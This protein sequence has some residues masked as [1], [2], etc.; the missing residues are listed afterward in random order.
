MPTIDD[1]GFTVEQKEFIKTI[2]EQ[3]RQKT[4]KAF[5]DRYGVKDIT[6]LDFLFDKAKLYDELKEREKE[7]KFVPSQKTLENFIG[8]EKAKE[9]ICKIVYLLEKQRRDEL[10]C[11]NA[12]CFAGEHGIGKVAIAQIFTKILF[13]KGLVTS[14]TPEVICADNL[15]GDDIKK[16][17]GSNT[18]KVVVIKD[19]CSMYGSFFGHERIGFLHNLYTAMDKS[20]K[21]ITI[22]CDTQTKLQSLL[23]EEKHLAGRVSA[24]IEFDH[25]SVDELYDILAVSLKKKEYAIDDGAVSELKRIIKHQTRLPEYSNARSLKM[26]MEKL[27]IIQATRTKEIFEDRVITLDD[28]YQYESQEKITRT[29]IDENNKE[30]E[31]KLNELIGLE[32]VKKQIKRLKAYALKNNSSSDNLN[33]HMCFTGNPGTGKTVVAKLVAGILYENGILPENKLIERDRSTLIGKYVGQTAPL[34]REAVNASLG[35]VLF[36][37]EAYALNSNGVEEDYGQEAIAEL[38]KC[39]EEQR[40]QFAVIFAGYKNETLAMIESNPGLKSRINRYVDFPNY[41]RDELIQITRYMVKQDGYYCS[42]SVVNKVCDI[43]E[44]NKEENNYGNARDVRNIL[45]S[46]YEI[47]AERTISNTRNRRII[48][49]DVES[50]IVDNRVKITNNKLTDI[51]ETKASLT[52]L[53]AKT[54]KPTQVDCE[55]IEERTVLIKN[56]KN[57]KENGE[58]TGFFISNSGIILTNDHVVRGSDEIRVRLSLYLKNGSKTYKECFAKIYKTNKE[59]DVAILKI[60]EKGEYPFIPMSSSI[61]NALTPV[62][63]GGYPYGASRLND[64]SFSEGVVQSINKD[65]AL[66]EGQETVD[67]IYVDIVGVPGN[68][69]SALINK[70][71]GEVVGIYSGASIHHQHGIAHEMKYAMP[72]KYAWELL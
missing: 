62:I 26:L 46:L 49:A 52:D 31:K 28:I 14:S 29:M 35:G 45:E 38:L 57:G 63:M 20:P 40:G 12:F 71:T 54:S 7:R 66:K 58:G 11:C 33:L 4:H 3:R 37:D 8:Q 47:Q 21:T 16:I 70:A 51:G 50:F 32:G 41:S 44:I 9:K 24:V 43:V 55:F 69:G 72:I 36:I 13:D 60:D 5:F 27:L 61:P 68:S 67:R 53:Y 65:S 2:M 25:Y 59:Q 42:N 10:K 6:E 64:I 19:T 39:M 17:Y 48:L 15:N 18:A 34:V 30:Y 1:F 56:M 22:F 23:K